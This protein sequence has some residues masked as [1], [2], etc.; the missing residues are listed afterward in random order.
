MVFVSFFGA[1]Y[2]CAAAA[3]VVSAF[4]DTI[5]AWLELEKSERGSRILRRS[6]KH[7]R[8]FKKMFH[9]DNALVCCSNALL[10]CAQVLTHERVLLFQ[11]FCSLMLQ[12]ENLLLPNELLSIK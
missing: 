3:A 5:W 10:L 2:Y 12:D 8:L 6:S 1:D 7:S 11:W 4:D 9:V